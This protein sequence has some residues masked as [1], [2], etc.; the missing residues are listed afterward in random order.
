MNKVLLTLLRFKVKHFMP[1]SDNHRQ[2][3]W[4][5]STHVWSASPNWSYRFM[6]FDSKWYRI[7]RRAS[8]SISSW[9]LAGPPWLSIL[10]FILGSSTYWQL[11]SILWRTALP[12][13]MKK[14]ESHVEIPSKA[15]RRSTFSQ[16]LWKRRCRWFDL[17]SDDYKQF[18]MAWIY[19]YCP[20]LRNCTYAN[21]L[22]WVYLNCP[23][24][25]VENWK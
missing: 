6:W 5:L 16:K 2:H 21:Y 11:Y 9:L 25:Q 12:L 15:V 22:P 19:R 8:F 20:R 17:L 23:F 14:V 24:R 7:V 3:Y 1:K 10:P 18:S 13:V 4:K